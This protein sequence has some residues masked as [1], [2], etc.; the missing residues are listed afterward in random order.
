MHD[1]VV[2]QINYMLKDNDEL[3]LIVGNKLMDL[4]SILNL[5]IKLQCGVENYDDNRFEVSLS[6]FEFED[7]DGN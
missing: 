7:K 2:E 6:K 5:I 1:L 4:Q 3:P